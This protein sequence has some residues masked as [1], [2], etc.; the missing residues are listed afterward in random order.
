MGVDGLADAFLAEHVW[1]HLSLEDAH[2][3]TRNCYRFLRPG[4][5]LRL[6]VPDP[7]WHLFPLESGAKDSGGKIRR[8]SQSA[9]KASSFPGK[10]NGPGDRKKR[11][12][13]EGERREDSRE[14]PEWLSSAM[15]AADIRDGHLVQYTPELLANVCWSAGFEP[16][17][18]EGGSRIRRRR[19]I[20]KR[21]VHGE[22]GGGRSIR[23]GVNDN[24][25]E[26]SWLRAG[27][28]EDHVEG[29]VDSSLW[30]V[31]KR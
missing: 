16:V 25:A 6:A 9:G 31:V 1:E 13:E 12:V 3:A 27:A 5:R 7:D 20:S 22:D 23:G 17:L 10:T 2:R 26:G 29:E 14:L 18:V 4:G 21:H 11:E 8:A 30:G 28:G 19:P 15:V 24:S